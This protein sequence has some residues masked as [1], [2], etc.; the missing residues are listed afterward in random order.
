MYTISEQTK[1]NIERVVGL[2]IEQIN[3]M[4]IEELDK[5]IEK[6]NNTKLTCPKEI[7]YKKLM[8]K[9]L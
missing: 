8:N 1:K 9:T 2:S 7:N 6:K 5:Y 3:N 4:S